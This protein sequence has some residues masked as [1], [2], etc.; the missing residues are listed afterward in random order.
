MG[1][2]SQKLF[3]SCFFK[4]FFFLRY[5]RNV[6]WSYCLMDFFPQFSPCFVYSFFFRRVLFFQCFFTKKCFFLKRCFFFLIRIVSSKKVFFI[7]KGLLFLEDW[8][9]LFFEEDC[10]FSKGIGFQFFEGMCFFFN[11]FCCFCKNKRDFF[12]TM[13][14]SSKIIFSIFSNGFLFRIFFSKKF[15]SEV[16]LFFSKIFHFKGFFFQMVCKQ[17]GSRWF[18]WKK[19]QGFFQKKN[20][21]C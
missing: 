5:F 6:S 20:V 19:N 12:F 2:F 14:F 7:K 16:S 3:S 11:L 10:F 1:F 4:G 21:F 17:K 8:Y 9:V 18:F 13:F 15:F